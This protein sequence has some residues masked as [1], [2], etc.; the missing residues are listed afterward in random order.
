MPKSV[1]RSKG[2]VFPIRLQPDDWTSGEWFFRFVIL[3]RLPHK[4]IH[5]NN[6]SEFPRPPLFTDYLRDNFYFPNLMS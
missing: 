2:A 1:N 4:S 3:N 5:L 6:W